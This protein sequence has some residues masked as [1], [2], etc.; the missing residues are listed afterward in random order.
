MSRKGQITSYFTRPLPKK[1]RGRPPK[2]QCPSPAPIAT[3]PLVGPQA[4]KLKLD[5]SRPEGHTNWSLPDNKAIMDE[6]V[7]GWLDGTAKRGKAE[8]L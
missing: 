5:K 1:K 2:V 8:T 7:N 3:V 6:A 4:K